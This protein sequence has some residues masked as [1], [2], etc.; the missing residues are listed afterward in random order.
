[1]PEESRRVRRGNLHHS[2]RTVIL[3][4][5]VT[6]A[7][8][9]RVAEVGRP[10]RVVDLGGGS[11]G[12][13]VPLAA[14]GHHVTVVDPSP[15]ALASLERRLRDADIPD[16]GQHL[17]AVQG[18]STVLAD[19]GLD[20]VDL[21]TCHGVLEVD[22]DP[23]RTLSDIAEALAPGGIL[24]L[25]VAQRLA[26]VLARAL[27][28]RFTQARSALQSEDGRYGEGDPMPRRYDQDQLCEFVIRS[29]LTVVDRRG[30]RVFTDLVPSAFV[31]SEVDREALLALERA[32]AEHADHEL[33]GRL[34]S[35]AHLLAR[36]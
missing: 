19:L 15:D 12:M 20:G 1:M 14:L 16:A 27:A 28:G 17:V 13:A 7:V 34:G 23:E 5:R 6:A 18:D 29:G 2:P 31:D 36:R 25:L 8:D 24:S 11:G 9:M 30:L 4:E 21:I 26:V 33:L 22:D 35:A 3:W 10:L 32:I